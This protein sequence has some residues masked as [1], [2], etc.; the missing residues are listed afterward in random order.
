V[1]EVATRGSLALNRH[2]AN[3]Y[4]LTE[5]EVMELLAH[6]PVSAV[7]IVTG[8]DNQIK[9]ISTLIQFVA[10]RPEELKDLP[11]F[12]E[13]QVFPAYVGNLRGKADHLGV[14]FKNSCGLRPYRSGKWSKTFMVLVQ[15]LPAALS[16]SEESALRLL[17]RMMELVNAPRFKFG[18]NLT[19]E[20]MLRR[21]KD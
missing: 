4:A 12:R 1:S 5:H 13:D 8:G 7:A 11:R 15:H 20:E 3:Q 19:E 17:R 14:V 16:V 10:P 18:E 21:L 2:P 9:G 6:G